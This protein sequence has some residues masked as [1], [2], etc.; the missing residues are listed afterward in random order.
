MSNPRN[1][2]YWY[3]T[4][5]V[6]TLA[7]GCF[8]PQQSKH[9]SPSETA[10]V[11]PASK[12]SPV[13]PLQSDSFRQAVNY[14]MKASTLSQ[15]AKS[16]TDWD[17]VVSNW[18]N[19]TDLMKAVPNS[20]PHYATAQ[21]KVEEYKK[22]LTYAQQQVTQ[23]SAMPT[24]SRSQVATQA[25]A[26]ESVL[27]ETAK[28]FFNRCVALEWNFDPAELD[29]YAQDALIQNTRR[30]PDGRTR[31]F[32]FSSEEWKALALD[33]LPLA[34]ARGDRNKYSQVVYTVEGNRV[35]ITAQRYSLLKK[36]TS[37]R[38]FLVGA[39]GTGEWKIFEDISESRP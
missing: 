3:I 23:A 27:I 33:A 25:Q 11:T 15:S 13:P 37:P 24:T 22:N 19:A 28:Q 5:I 38:S 7:V 29:L 10:A 1:L 2:S 21:K 16:K 39:D 36:Y 17:S 4:T 34:Q 12:A 20:S 14:A 8:S 26:N 32:R 6:L 30:Y 9:S 31:M 35:R 18:Q